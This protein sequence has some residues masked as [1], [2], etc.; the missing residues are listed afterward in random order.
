MRN[1]LNSRGGQENLPEDLKPN[2]EMM[3]YFIFEIP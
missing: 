2:M 1:Y 3:G